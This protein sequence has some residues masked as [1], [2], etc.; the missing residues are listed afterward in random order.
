MARPRGFKESN[1]T[2]MPGDHPGHEVQPLPVFNNGDFCMS[3]WRLSLQERF[4][5]LLF[6]RVWLYVLSG[7]T[8]P[9]VWIAVMRRG[10]LRKA[11]KPKTDEENETK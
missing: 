1:R 5:A 7:S 2:L 3:S 11:R 4:S 8:Q 10:F 9:P 6:G